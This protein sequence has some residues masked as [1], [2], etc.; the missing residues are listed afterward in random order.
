[1]YNLAI[2]PPVLVCRRQ[3]LALKHIVSYNKIDKVNSK[4]RVVNNSF[5]LITNRRFM[6]S[7]MTAMNRSSSFRGKINSGMA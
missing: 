4:S 3:I 2:R 5:K 7:K 1:M 6:V